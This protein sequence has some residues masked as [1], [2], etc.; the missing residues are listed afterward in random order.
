MH[1]V[2][3]LHRQR[4]HRQQLLLMYAWKVTSTFLRRW[5]HVLKR[6]ETAHVIHGQRWVKGK[7]F[8]RRKILVIQASWLLIRD[9]IVPALYPMLKIYVQ[10]CNQL[11][12]KRHFFLSISDFGIQQLIDTW[13]I[14]PKF[15]FF[16]S[17]VKAENFR[18]KKF[19]KHG[20]TDCSHIKAMGDLGHQII[21]ESHLLLETPR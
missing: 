13:F 7:G 5:K 1:L 18:D 10:V 19:Y 14:W 17:K 8:I 20:E 16:F 9:Q 11:I 6:R 21:R 2:H 4:R 3:I 15:I 12:Q